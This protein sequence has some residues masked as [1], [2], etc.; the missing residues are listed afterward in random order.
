[1]K[2]QCKNTK[3]SKN[4]NYKKKIRTLI[5]STILSLLLFIPEDVKAAS[6]MSEKNNGDLY[7]KIVNNVMSSFKASAKNDDKS[8]LAMFNLNPLNIVK[9]EISYLE[10]KNFKEEFTKDEIINQSK[11]VEQIVINPFNLSESEISKQENKVETAGNPEDNSKKKILIYHSHTS[12]AYSPGETRKVDQNQN[13]VAVGEML[14]KELQKQG[15]TVIHD[16][17]VHDLD[18]NKSYYKS[19][20]TISKYYSKYGNFDFVIDMHRDSGP[21]RKYVISKINDESIAR[22][23]FVTTTKDPRYK[24]HM[25]NINSIFSIAEKL[26]PTLF[27]E[28]NIHTNLSGIKYYNQD[29]SD[30]AVLLEVG[31]TSNNLQEALNSMKYLSRVLAEHINNRGKK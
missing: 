10:N 18:Y 3:L 15:F 17:T 25:S 21:D 20:E 24:A 23:M 30:N 19:R 16:K 9:N 28:R 4:T 12:E 6:E 11:V 13:I 14:T 22:L 7:L 8:I 31:A 27:R 5:L 26:Y 2:Y 1:M 29:L